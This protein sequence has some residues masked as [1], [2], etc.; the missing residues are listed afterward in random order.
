MGLEY[1]S[2]LRP[3]QYP[4]TFTNSSLHA[5]SFKL[6]SSCHV[7]ASPRL[8]GP[9]KYV[10]KRP[11]TLERDKRQLGCRLL[12]SRWSDVPGQGSEVA[13]MRHEPSASGLQQTPEGYSRFHLG[14]RRALLAWAGDYSA[15]ASDSTWHAGSCSFTVF[16]HLGKRIQ[17]KEVQSLGK[18]V[19]PAM[20][21]ALPKV[22]WRWTK[23]RYNTAI[24][25]IGSLLTFRGNL[26]EGAEVFGSECIRPHSHKEPF[27]LGLAACTLHKMQHTVQALCIHM[28]LHVY[29][30][31]YRFYML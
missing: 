29:V 26:E 5:L 14:V 27:Q 24:L 12:G 4:P 22:T 7:E 20:K 1:R 17:L 19:S 9:P 28:F 21:I 2:S 3:V 18:R 31:A 16:D 13:R 15:V 8:P 10:N 30:N 11:K 23:A 6:L 25:G